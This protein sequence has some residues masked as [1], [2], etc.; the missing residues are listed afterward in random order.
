QAILDGEI[1]L[2]MVAAKNV[3]MLDEFQDV[4]QIEFDFL[5]AIKK[6]AGEPRMIAAGDDDQNIYEFR[7]ASVQ[8]MQRLVEGEKARTY[9][10]T[11]NYRSGQHIVEFSNS[12]L[13]FLPTSRLKSRTVLRSKREQPGAVQMVKY[14]Q[15]GFIEA[16]CQSIARADLKGTI[17]VLTYS[18]EEAYLTASRLKNLGMPATLVASTKEFQLK[19]LIELKE[20]SFLLEKAVNSVSGWISNEIW[21]KLKQKLKAKYERSVDWPLVDK[22]IH[23]FDREKKYKYRVDW[24]EYINHAKI[25]DFYSEEKGRVFVSTMHKIKGKQFDKVFLLLDSFKLKGDAEAR[26]VYVAITRPRNY[27]EVHTHLPIF[28]QIATPGLKKTTGNSSTESLPFFTI[29]CSLSDVVLSHFHNDDIKARVKL[30][31]TGDELEF[32]QGTKF[33]RAALPGQWNEMAACFSLSL[34]S[35]LDQHFAKG[36]KVKSLRVGH[37]VYWW[38]KEMEA[39]VR[40]VLPE[41]EL[42]K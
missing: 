16:F 10:L 26:V 13:G 2:E 18:N 27:L 22:I 20:F 34:K 40:V 32:S 17:G 37:I 31:M 7:G 1:T 14:A 19:N 39:G 23:T 4:S 15:K 36:Y 25:E 24:L 28:D 29:Q 12:F 5:N 8:F 21:N 35:T 3:I 33:Y 6:V 38:D 42:G 11:D 41:V 9:F 30:L